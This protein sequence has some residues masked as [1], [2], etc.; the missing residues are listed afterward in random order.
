MRNR[1]KLFIQQNFGLLGFGLLLSY[2]S[3]FG[4]T[5]LLSLYLPDLEKLLS[6]GNTELGGLYA[7]ATIGSALALPLLGGYFDKVPLRSYAVA[8]ITGLVASLLLLSFAQS[9]GL[10]GLAFF[11]LRLFGQ[12]LMSHT[13]SSSMARYFDKN[14]GKAI[15]IASV[16]HPLSEATMPLVI[17]LLIG[18]LGWRGTLQASAGLCVLGVIPLAL[19]LIYCSKERVEQAYWKT[20]SVAFPKDKVRVLKFI[21]ERRFW[22]ISPL[23]FIMGF[24]NTAIFF[25]QLKLGAA[26]GWSA[27]WVALS[28]SAFAIGGA[29]GMLASG[30][31]V[32]RFTGRKL[33]PYFILPYLLGLVLLTFFEQ[34]LTYPAALALIGFANGMGSTVKSAMLAEIYGTEVIGRIRSLFTMIMVL[35]TALGPVSFGVLLD[36]GLSFSVIYG[37]AGILMLVFSVNALRR[38]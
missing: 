26:R 33:F 3:G 31:M 36:Q 14:R 25:F 13:S 29:V 4:Q 5:F 12:G 2:F 35:S 7:M 38:L 24:T 23:S 34:P 8:I 9:V 16:G 17:T 21:L 28:V 18:V 22:V 20:K 6:I 27:E 37:L 19:L 32:D 11:G 30:P 15:S 10:V 1:I